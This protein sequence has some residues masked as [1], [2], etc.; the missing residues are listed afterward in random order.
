MPNERLSFV[1][2][3]QQV[4]DPTIRRG[5]DTIRTEHPC[6]LSAN[7]HFRGRKSREAYLH[8]AES[9]AASTHRR[10]VSQ[11]RVRMKSLVLQS[12]P[13]KFATR[14]DSGTFFCHVVHLSAAIAR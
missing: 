10:T 4:S 9:E 12:G 6:A 11:A 5:V 3:L 14:K 8:F 1:L 2:T 7:S 13:R